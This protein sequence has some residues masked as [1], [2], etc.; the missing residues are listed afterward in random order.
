METKHFQSAASTEEVLLFRYTLC[1]NKKRNCKSK[2]KTKSEKQKRQKFNG[3]IL[4]DSFFLIFN[5][6]TL[7]STCLAGSS[8][9]AL[10]RW[11]S[12]DW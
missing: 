2:S 9:Y 5:F 10:S 8:T 3:L 6:D 4:D 7:A 11:R 1:N 12:N